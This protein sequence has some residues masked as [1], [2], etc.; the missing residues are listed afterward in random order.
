MDFSKEQIEKA[1]SCKTLEELKEFAKNEGIEI[2][3]EKAKQYFAA[4]H[5]GELNDDELNAVAGGKNEPKPKF[6]VGDYVRLIKVRKSPYFPTIKEGKIF[7]MLF[8]KNCKEWF[9]YVGI[10]D[11]QYLTEEPEHN[12]ELCPKK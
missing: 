11:G 8:F 10:N 4:T 12:L 3:D 6:K 7:K 5:C 1:K 9:Y 2:S